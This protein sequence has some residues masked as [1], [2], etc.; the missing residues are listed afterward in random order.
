MR[1]VLVEPGRGRGVRRAGTPW[2]PDGSPW[3]AGDVARRVITAIT[4]VTHLPKEAVWVVFEEV[5]PPDRSSPANRASDCRRI[6]RLPLSTARGTEEPTESAPRRDAPAQGGARRKPAS[7]PARPLRFPSGRL[8]RWSALRRDAPAGRRRKLTSSPRRVGN[9][10]HVAFRH[11]HAT[12][13]ST[14]TTDENSAAR[15]HPVGIQIGLA[16]PHEPG[17]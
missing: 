3:L 8:S 14:V 1:L 6:D 15:R 7:S 4:D 9:L 2:S 11:S 12:P 13:Q 16:I 5:D 17:K 10:L